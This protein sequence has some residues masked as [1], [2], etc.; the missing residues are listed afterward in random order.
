METS[1][2]QHKINSL[3]KKCNALT[4]KT[5]KKVFLKEHK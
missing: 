5:A 1:K 2:G 4:I 3:E